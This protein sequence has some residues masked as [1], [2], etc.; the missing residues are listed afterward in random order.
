MDWTPVLVAVLSSGTLVAIVTALSNR[1]VTSAQ[2]TMTL[3]EGYETRLARLS[4]RACLL[5]GKV[6]VLE[7]QVSTFRSLLS[8]R[9][10]TIVN[11]Q[12][13]NIDLQN[14]IGKLQKS[15]LC[16][17]KRIKELERLVSENEKEIDSFRSQVA[18]LTTRL[19][20]MNGQQQ[21]GYAG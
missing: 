17:D 6:E 11:L 20:A 9:E 4:E 7:T 15:I 14:E 3:S 10:V 18:E 5:E 2:A 8:E 16:R 13:E 12:Q 21:D 1:R 19:D